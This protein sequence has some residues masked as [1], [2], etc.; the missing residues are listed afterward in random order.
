MV[1]SLAEM[2][3]SIGIKS[4][5]AFAVGGRKAHSMLQVYF[6]NNK[7]GLFDPFNGVIYI[8]RSNGTPISLS[9]VFNYLTKGSTAVLYAR[10]KIEDPDGP[11]LSSQYALSPDS[12]RPDYAFPG[13]FTEAKALGLANSGFSTTIQIVLSPH[14]MV[15]PAN[16]VRSTDEP[17]PWTKLSLWRLSSGEYLS[18]AYIL[19]QSSLGYLV[20]HAYSLERLDIGTSYTLRIKIANAYVPRGGAVA[21]PAITLQPVV[22]FRPPAFVS[23][24]NRGYADGN[25]YVFQTA[26]ISFVA[27][28]TTAT[29]IAHATGTVH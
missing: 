22:P 7:E 13:I 29:I 16:W 4:R 9:T 1:A 2:L 20:E 12:D 27:N 24:E 15:G 14:S 11:V 23:L 25:E 8:D 26:E 10:R 17:K 6:S 5:Y 21:N 28:S 19:G 3:Y 18:W